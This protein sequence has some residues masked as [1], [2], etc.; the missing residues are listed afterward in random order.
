M[1]KF[2]FDVTDGA[3]M[4]DVVG[5]ELADIDAA[6]AHAI[7]LSVSLLTQY[8]PRFWKGEEWLIEARDDCGLALFTLCFR[9]IETP[10]TRSRPLLTL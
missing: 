9:A 10:I 1:P 3:F 5:L 8:S 4:P 6:R 7:A 2:F